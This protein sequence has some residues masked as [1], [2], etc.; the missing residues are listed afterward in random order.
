MSRSPLSRRDLLRSS[1]AL[2]LAT[3]AAPLSGAALREPEPTAAG[4][5]V[6]R[7][8]PSG[9]G[10]I[11]IEEVR[12][13]FAFSRQSRAVVPMNAANL[14]PTFASITQ[15]VAAR[16]ARLDLDV[17]F[18]NRAATVF[19]DLTAA[20]T[21]VARQLG[22]AP[23]DLALVRNTSEANN[24]LAAGLPLADDDVVLL[25]N[26][27]H[28][29]NYHSWFFRQQAELARGRKIRIECVT[30]PTPTSELTRAA[31]LRTFGDAISQHKPRVV[32]FTEVSNVSGVRL[33]SKEIAAMAHAARK[34]AFVHVDGAQ[35]W[36]ALDLDL[37]AMGCDSFSASAHKWFCGPRETGLLYVQKK[38]L[39]DDGA[40]ER[41][42]PSVVA[43]DLYIKL[44]CKTGGET[45]VPGVSTAALAAFEGWAGAGASCGMDCEL[46]N[47]AR[48]FETLG[49]RDD[50]AVA[51]LGET[52]DLHR[53]I[54]PAKIEAYVADLAGELVR[55]LSRCSKVT[56]TTPTA[57]DARHG[58]VV[59]HL[60][61]EAEAKAVYD[62]LYGTFRIYGA[63][64]SA[65]GKVT[66]VR[67]CPHM[68]NAKE[69]VLK[70]LT[71]VR[72][73]LGC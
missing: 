47:D 1:A 41:F 67:L 8:E 59:F 40:K 13:L 27:N 57:T 29:T 3:V 14:C 17:S 69:D 54:G 61:S 11:P 15:E 20:R 63:P 37:T 50:A 16:T 12:K 2:G 32:A 46:W 25:W 39:E 34:D 23:T 19:P 73:I 10:A 4:S 52:A 44:P 22:I 38:W 60:P 56:L 33:P 58:V 53:R 45:E 48:R 62:G 6:P 49:Q 28:P 71:G 70:A 31:I 36:G 24:I 68:Y 55:G 42:W 21:K 26:E 66:G 5:A 51:A 72:S 7:V 30:L 9:D 35:S 65:S 64:A 18:Q 43:Y